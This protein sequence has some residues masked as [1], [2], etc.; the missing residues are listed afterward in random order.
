[1]DGTPLPNTFPALSIETD[2]LPVSIKNTEVTATGYPVGTSIN[3]TDTGLYATGAT[4]TISDLYTFGSN[5]ADVIAIRG[6]NVG[7][8]G[9]SGGPIA[10]RDGVAIGMITTRGDDEIDGAGSLRAITL[11]HIDR[12]ITEET[13]YSLAQHMSGDIDTKAALFSQTIS[14]FLVSLLTS[15]MNP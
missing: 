2:L 9:S 11:S 15:E 12:T 1:M 14:P 10:T 13:G 4:T 3:D 6:T 5:Y 8:Q 7:A